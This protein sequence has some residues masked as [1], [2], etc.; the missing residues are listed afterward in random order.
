MDVLRGKPDPKGYLFPV[1]VENLAVKKLQPIF[2]GEGEDPWRSPGR[3]PR[4]AGYRRNLMEG[5]GV[6]K[7]PR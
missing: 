4:G 7:V 2:Q 3:P 1:N 6:N 5:G